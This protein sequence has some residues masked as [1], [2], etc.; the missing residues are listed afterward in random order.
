MDTHEA[1]RILGVAAYEVLELRHDAEGWWAHHEDMASHI[2][3]WR[4]IPSWQLTTEDA[5]TVS[6]Q[7]DAGEAGP[8]VAPDSPQEV[9]TGP[10]V[11]IDGDG[12]PEGTSAQILKWVGSDSDRAERAL[13]AEAGRDKPRGVL[14]AALEKLTT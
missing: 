1:A 9:A 3:I 10:A 2:R 6:V 5:S 14:T 11:D 8:D 13:A 7:A 4:H 12:V